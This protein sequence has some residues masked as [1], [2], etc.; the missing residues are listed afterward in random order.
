MSEQHKAVVRRIY[1]EVFGQGRLEVVDELL[2]A[3]AIDHE[4]EGGTGPQTLKDAAG[5]FRAAF[6]DLKVTADDMMAD[7]DK[8]IARARFT[9]TH[10]GEFMGIAP[11]GKSVEVGMIDIIRFADGKAVEH[12]GISDNMALMQQLGAAPPMG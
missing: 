3:D 1:D 4:G 9:G 5:M 6:P 11:T 7:G 2:S 8:V 12:W 10:N